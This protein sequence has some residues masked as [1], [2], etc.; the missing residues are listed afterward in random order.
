MCRDRQGKSVLRFLENPAL[1]CLTEKAAN[2]FQGLSKRP[3]MNH[4][5]SWP[6][7]TRPSTSFLLYCKEDVDARRKAG[8]DGA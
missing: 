3:I 2:I 5:S 1:R 8:H 6:G 7:L 4:F